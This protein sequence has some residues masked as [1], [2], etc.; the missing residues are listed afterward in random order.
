M[1]DKS[2]YQAAGQYTCTV[3]LNTAS[4]S[5]ANSSASVA[6]TGPGRLCEFWM[7]T[8][9]INSVTLYDNS[10]G[11]GGGVLF[12]TPINTANPVKYTINLPY[13]NGIWVSS[14]TNGPTIAFSFALSGV[15]GTAP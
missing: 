14:A 1:P 10:T 3:T 2:A 8:N 13:Q 15:G 9:A 12:N 5:L 4:N 6:S 7:L 11:P